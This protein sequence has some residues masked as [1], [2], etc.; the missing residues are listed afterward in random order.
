[1]YAAAMP[2]PVRISD[3]SFRIPDIASFARI[4]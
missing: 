3:I 4:F 1:M 2:S